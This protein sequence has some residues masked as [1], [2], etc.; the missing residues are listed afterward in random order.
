M[1]LLGNCQLGSDCCFSYACAADCRSQI[2]GPRFVLG[3]SL[4]GPWSVVCTWNSKVSHSHLVLPIRM[5][6]ACVVIC[7]SCH[8]DISS[9]Q[10]ATREIFR[11]RSAIGSPLVDHTD[12]HRTATVQSSG[13]IC[14]QFLSVAMA[15]AS[16]AASDAGNTVGDTV[17]SETF[18]HILDVP[19]SQKYSTAADLST[20]L[21]QMNDAPPEHIAK[22]IPILTCLACQIASK[23]SHGHNKSA[24]D[25]VNGLS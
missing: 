7:I 21:Q 9:S 18:Q 24:V 19:Q 3:H 17:G 6:G 25:C 20:L 2:V 12:L 22:L 13:C 16:A 15:S 11:R 14:G 10:N 8:L 5:S 4:L 1:L 23:V